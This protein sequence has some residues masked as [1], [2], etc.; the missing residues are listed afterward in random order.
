MLLIHG[1]VGYTEEYPVERRLRDTIG[2]EIGDGTA[3]IM[4]TIVARELLGREFLPY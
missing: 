2:L 4:K 3:D 1:H